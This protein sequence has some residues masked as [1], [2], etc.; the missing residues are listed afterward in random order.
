MI[1]PYFLWKIKFNLKKRDKTDDIV[2]NLR[3]ARSILVICENKTSDVMSFISDMREFLP[4]AKISTWIFN[5]LNDDLKTRNRGVKES[6]IR[7]VRTKK[8]DLVIDLT[9]YEEIPWLYFVSNFQTKVNVG[10]IQSDKQGIFNLLMN[11][12]DKTKIDYNFL[13]EYLRRLVST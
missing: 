8:Y 11:P 13:I 1:K 12:S 6:E 10:I 3:E 4:K 2:S 9:G 7:K 5:K